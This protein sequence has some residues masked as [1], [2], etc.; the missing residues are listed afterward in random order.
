MQKTHR[1]LLSPVL[2]LQ[3]SIND[4]TKFKQS[5][6]AR[7]VHVAFSGV[8]VMGRLENGEKSLVG[9]YHWLTVGP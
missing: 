9:G 2:S 1:H 4:F 7:E 6:D 5:D 3:N 8:K